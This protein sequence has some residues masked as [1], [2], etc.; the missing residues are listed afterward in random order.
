MYIANQAAFD[1]FL[2]TADAFWAEHGS[3]ATIN[4]VIYVDL[5]HD[6]PVYLLTNLWIAK[7]LGRLTGAGVVGLTAAWPESIP[8]YDEAA[9]R[10][11]AQAFLIDD[12]RRVDL[13]SL[14]DDASLAAFQAAVDGLDGHAL[15]Q[16][17]LTF[18]ADTDPDIGWVL[19]DT[20]IRGRRVASLEHPSDSLIDYAKSVLRARA[21][22]RAAMA[23]RQAVACVVG[24][25]H[26]SPYAWMARE[27][28]LHGAPVYFQS[29]LLPVSIR[30]F[31]TLAD[32]RRGVPADFHERYRKDVV[33]VLPDGQIDAFQRRMF[34]IQG[35]TRQFFRTVSQ[36]LASRSRED[37]LKALGL[38]PSLPCVC[39]YVPALCGPSHC[40]G[41]LAFDDHADWL[42]A[43]LDIALETPGVN[44][45]VKSHPQDAT[46]DLSGF[47]SR[48]AKTYAE[49][50]N[51]HFLDEAMSPAEIAS[52]TDLAVTVSG[53]PGYELAARGV[54][55]LAAGPSRYSGL[56]F[57]IDAASLSE[58]RAWLTHPA[59]TVMDDARVQAALCFMFF[60]MTAGRSQSLFL[61]HLRLASATELWEDVT[62][63]LLATLPEEDPLWRNLCHM[64]DA[65]LP[66]LLNADV[67]PA[68]THPVRTRTAVDVAMAG[69]YAVSARSQARMAAR[70]DEMRGVLAE[71]EA[72]LERARILCGVIG[73]SERKLRFGTGESGNDFL[74]MGWSVPESGGVWTDGRY[75]SIEFPPLPH[76]I[77]VVVEGYAYVD[78][79]SPERH[80]AIRCGEGMPEV[81]LLL[82]GNPTEIRVI[83]ERS[84][85][86][87][88]NLRISIGNPKVP[89][90]GHRQ[91]GFWLSAV[92]FEFPE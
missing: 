52:L 64:V 25:Y 85:D 72:L 91:L 50:A 4:G 55:T 35:G 60:E 41:P 8:H 27:A 24:H 40:F 51:V 45:L 10:R 83:A 9:V 26:Y 2:S 74:G 32:F 92:R 69:M 78:A 80:V 54:A 58:Y 76:G 31:A 5:A 43:T 34:D 44:F 1:A 87:S 81:R 65:D 16:A 88:T 33:D 77:A 56:G 6:N 61:P 89:L 17:V 42:R 23:D 68:S 14:D 70:V 22:V 66:F 46:Y 57:S 62:R 7:Y 53:T 48:C 20:W 79:A 12:V 19:Y 29:L 59:S 73:R 13:P 11:L 47:V 38:D 49:H 15:R 84:A 28:L 3:A 75:A 82:D 90:G 86:S 21:G 71:R 18:A 39:I 67:V 36:G 37:S 63:R 30:R